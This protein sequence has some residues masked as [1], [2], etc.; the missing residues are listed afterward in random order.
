MEYFT[1]AT[2]RFTGRQDLDLINKRLEIALKKANCF[3][4]NSYKLTAD[5]K[6]I[7]IELYD[8]FNFDSV[9]L[10]VQTL[11]AMGLKKFGRDKLIAYQTT[12]CC[13]FVNYVTKDGE[14]LTFCRDYQY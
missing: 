8:N 3:R 6:K 10:L 13:H 9:D 11:I 4:K 5:N 12:A 1:D 7:F 14:F 2:I